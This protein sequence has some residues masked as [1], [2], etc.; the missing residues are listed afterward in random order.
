MIIEW[1]LVDDI[2]FDYN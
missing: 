2:E 1:M